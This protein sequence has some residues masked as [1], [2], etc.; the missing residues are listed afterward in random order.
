MLDRPD[1]SDLRE[2]Y[3]SHGKKYSRSKEKKRKESSSQYNN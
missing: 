3:E 2:Y 1:N